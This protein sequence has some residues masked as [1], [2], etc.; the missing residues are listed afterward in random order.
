MT[1]EVLIL[2]PSLTLHNL[3]CGTTS[4]HSMCRNKILAIWRPTQSKNM[5]CTSTLKAITACSF[6]LSKEMERERNINREKVVIILSYCQFRGILH[7]IHNLSIISMPV[8]LEGK[9]KK[10]W[11]L[12]PLSR[13]VK[14]K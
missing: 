4:I 11:S 10:I 6:F 1:Y 3:C 5:R 14:C 9:R 13:F 8:T 7:L 12:V 2:T